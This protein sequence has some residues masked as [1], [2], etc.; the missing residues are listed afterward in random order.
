MNELVRDWKA[1]KKDLEEA[2]DIIADKLVKADAEIERLKAELEAEKKT[3]DKFLHD[4]Q[5]Q[6][7]L[8]GNYMAKLFT[9][10]EL[11]TELANALDYRPEVQKWTLPLIQR[12]REA[13]Q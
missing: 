8:A 3:A 10:Q 6:T 7:R 2:F 13:T 9:A 4:L 1:E 11:I 5:T 12:A